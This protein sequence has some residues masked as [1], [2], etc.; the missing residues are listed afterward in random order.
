MYRDGDF[1]DYPGDRTADSMI[2]FAE[3]LSL[4]SIYLAKSYQEVMDH[5]TNNG[6]GGK[7]VAFVAYDGTFKLDSPSDN[8]T[9]DEVLE[10]I[11]Q[12]TIQMQVFGQI[13]RKQ[14]PF[15]NFILIHPETPK[16]DVAKLGAGLEVRMNLCST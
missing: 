8:E 10:K 4:N 11:I 14:Q 1:F 6:V 16:S 12:S 5:V 2:D 7:K 3:K 15:D 9:E 13:A